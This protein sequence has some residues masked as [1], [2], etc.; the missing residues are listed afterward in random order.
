M[1]L[2]CL[3]LLL[4]VTSAFGQ[5]S[6][7][8]TSDEIVRDFNN[9]SLRED[10]SGM[11]ALIHP[12]SMKEFRAVMLAMADK[13][14]TI[15]LL[16]GVRSKAELD[17][18][19]DADMFERI[20]ANLKAAE[21]GMDAAIKSMQLVVVGSVDEA[22]DLRHIIYRVKFDLFAN[23]FTAVDLYTLKRYQKS[24][25]VLLKEEQLRGM[26]IGIAQAKKAAPPAKKTPPKT[27]KRP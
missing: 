24:W 12:D 6:D 7:E 20:F 5:S 27:K 22:P 25:R 16:F 23:P 18:L 8:R 10:W 14:D 26:A 1:K 2:L 11:T 9:Y 15:R 4:I 3:L 17:A 21:P 13:P 19:T